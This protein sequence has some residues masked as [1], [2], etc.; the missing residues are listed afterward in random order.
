MSKLRLLLVDDEPLIRKGL[1]DALFE[2]SDIEIIG[3]C[4][5]GEEAIQAIATKQPDIVLL[6]VRMPGCSGLDVVREVGATRMPPVIFITAYDDYAVN[7]FELNAVDYLLKPFEEARL[8]ESIGRARRRIAENSQATLSQRLEAL[9]E[10]QTRKWTERIIVRNGERYEFVSSESIDWI[11]SANNYVQLHCGA[12][13]YLLGETMTS[14]EKRL[15]PEKF[16]RVHRGRIVNTKRILA[17]HPLFS[18]TYELELL[19]GIR[20]TTGRLYKDIV[21]N[22]I[23]G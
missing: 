20:I 21:Q 8:L 22:L 19:G 18:S 16:V 6:D 4:G 12:Q 15:D 23:H 17:V 11:E 2:V 10:G 14:L 3:E 1:R 5:S 9:I 13:H 7:A